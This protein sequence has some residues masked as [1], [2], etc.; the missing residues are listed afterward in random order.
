MA[1]GEVRSERLVG[2]DAGE[3]LSHSVGG[4]RGLGNVTA[5]GIL[6]ERRLDTGDIAGLVQ[7]VGAP[8][9]GWCLPMVRCQELRRLEGSARD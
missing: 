6:D 8:L 5:T 9:L 7:A 2:D 1:V 4:D 3:V